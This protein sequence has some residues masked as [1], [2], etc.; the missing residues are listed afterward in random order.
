MGILKQSTIGHR[1]TKKCDC[2][3]VFEF[4]DL[5]VKTWQSFGCK[6]CGRGQLFRPKTICE[7]CFAWQEDRRKS[8]DED[9]EKIRES[10]AR[11]PEWYGDGKSYLEVY[12]DIV[13]RRKNVGRNIM[14][15]NFNKDKNQKI[16]N[17]FDQMN[18]I[19][20]NYMDQNSID[21][22]LDRKNVYIGNVGSDITKNVI[23]E[24]NKNIK[25]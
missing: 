1:I 13:S 16:K 17:L 25:K 24:I 18:P 11:F 10:R 12:D 5:A 22:L 20:Q 4:T 3:G 7:G 8:R 9:E 23:D 2:D 14:V 6:S 21:I 15:S 19:I